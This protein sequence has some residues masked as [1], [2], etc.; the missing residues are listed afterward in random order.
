LD[1]EQLAKSGGAPEQ[2]KH[3]CLIG[4]AELARA[5]VAGEKAT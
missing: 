2:Y 4:D 1:R 3:P 5:V